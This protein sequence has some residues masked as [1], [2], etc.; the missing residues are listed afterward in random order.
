MSGAVEKQ[1]PVAGFQNLVDAGFVPIRG[2][3]EELSVIRV[4]GDA[5]GGADP[6][7][8][9]RAA[10]QGGD[11]VVRKTEGVVR[12]EIVV[13]VLDAVL[14]QTAEGADPDLAVRVFGE[15]LDA[16]VGDAVSDD[17]AAL[18]A[19]VPGCGMRPGTGGGEQEGKDPG[20]KSH[21]DG[22]Y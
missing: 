6:E 18:D 13:V 17:D 4:Q 7:L 20:M 16:L 14:V 21:G 5:V 22:A 12:A 8:T 1:P 15:R 11:M 19:F 3:T 2:D 9:G 10:V